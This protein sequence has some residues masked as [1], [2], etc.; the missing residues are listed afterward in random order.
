MAAPILSQDRLQY[1]FEYDSI[2]GEFT[3]LTNTQKNKI[4]SV[5]NSLDSN[6][7]V[8]VT[9]DGYSYLCHRLVYLY[10]YGYMPKEI[11][12]INGNRSDNRLCNLREATRQ[13]NLRNQKM[14]KT[15][16]SGFKCVSFAANVGK[17]RA[18]CRDGVSSVHIGYFHTAEEASAAY[19]KYAQEN[20]GN[21]YYKIGR[22]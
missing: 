6:G 5:V 11:D 1:L 18:R 9:I 16:T 3:R 21:F 20:Q 8:R 13:Q 22:K 19:E 17:W 7:Y 12:H 10:K 15:N 4:G 14:Q 2:T